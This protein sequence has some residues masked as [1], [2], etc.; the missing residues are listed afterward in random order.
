M[1]RITMRIM[2]TS[3]MAWSRMVLI[4]LTS[5]MMMVMTR[6]VRIIILDALPIYF[7]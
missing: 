3:S 5:S 1:I 6:M 4:R 7:Q 2:T